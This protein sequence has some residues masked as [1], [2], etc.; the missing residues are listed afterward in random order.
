MYTEVSSKR[1]SWSYFVTGLFGLNPDAFT[2]RNLEVEQN[3]IRN[4]LIT[5]HLTLQSPHDTSLSN[6]FSWINVKD[7]WNDCSAKIASKELAIALP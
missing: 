7:K 1:K 2:R 6:F 5:K 4:V 3:K